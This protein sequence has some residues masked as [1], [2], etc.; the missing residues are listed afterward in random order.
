MGG[1]HRVAGRSVCQL[2]EVVCSKLVAAMEALVGKVGDGFCHCTERRWGFC[3]PHGK[4][5]WKGQKRLLARQGGNGDGKRRNGGNVEPYPIKTV[6]NVDF[7]KLDRAKT[8]VGVHGLGEDPFKGSP[9]LHGFPWCQ[10]DS[11]AIDA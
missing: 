2:F 7:E 6:R 11:V 3:P 10:C 5:Q 8:W 9:K 1:Q 4:R